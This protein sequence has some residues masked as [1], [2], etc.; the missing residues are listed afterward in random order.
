MVTSIWESNQKF[1]LP[2]LLNSPS[3]KRH[4][5][6]SSAMGKIIPLRAH[7]NVS[8]GAKSNSISILLRFVQ[9]SALYS[10]LCRP[11]M[12]ITYRWVGEW[13]SIHRYTSYIFVL[14][15]IPHPRKQCLHS[16]YD[17]ILELIRW[18]IPSGV[19]FCLVFLHVTHIWST[20]NQTRT[21][22]TTKKKETLTT[23][24]TTTRIYPMVQKYTGEGGMA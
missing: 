14:Q 12:C 1:N 4:S 6:S 16:D 2:T 22:K 21:A 13:V 23:T 8:W 24:T 20:P 9:S 17:W 19:V 3:I 7:Q 10:L 11:Y 15:R 18:Q 5:P